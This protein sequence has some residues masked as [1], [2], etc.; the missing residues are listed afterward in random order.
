VERG[1][2][3]CGKEFKR[4]LTHGEMIDCEGPEPKALS[5]FKCKIYRS[6]KATAHP[7]FLQLISK[8]GLSEREIAQ[9]A[10]LH[11]KPVHL[12]CSGK[13]VREKTAQKIIEIILQKEKETNARRSGVSQGKLIL[14]S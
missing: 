13:Q 8:L 7:E 2:E 11:R 12:F 5:D 14:M 3:Y 4:K 9:R 10:K 6:G 1:R